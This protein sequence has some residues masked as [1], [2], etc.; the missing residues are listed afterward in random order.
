MELELGVG[1]SVSMGV[2]EEVIEGEGEG[3]AELST[4]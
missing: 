2:E 4:L 3:C 1:E